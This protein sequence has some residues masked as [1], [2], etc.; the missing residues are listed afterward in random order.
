[1]TNREYQKF[2]DAGAYQ[3]RE[4][5]KERFVKDGKELTWEQ[6]MDLFRDPTGRPGPSTW[7]GGH[8]PQGQSGYPVSGVSWYEASAYAAFAGKSLPA[9]GQWYKTASSEMLRLP[10]IKVILTAAGPCRRAVPKL[11]ARTGHTI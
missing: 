5:W 6:A 1:V 4:Y 2:V 9:L 7:E 3:K 8:F 11:W 10:S